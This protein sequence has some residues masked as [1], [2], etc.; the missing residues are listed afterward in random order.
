[1]DRIAADP[2]LLRVDELAEALGTGTRRPQRIFAEYVGV[3][4]KWV[5]RRYRMQE[6]ANRAGAGVDWAALSAELGYADQAH[7]TRDFSRV[8][9][10]SPAQYARDC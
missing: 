1:M 2:A 8:I 4:P 10:I 9:G 7:F 6:A 3:A 5:I